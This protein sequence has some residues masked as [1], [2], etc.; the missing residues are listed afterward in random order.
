MCLISLTLVVQ[1]SWLID[2]FSNQLPGDK[3]PDKVSS[4]VT[5]TQWSLAQKASI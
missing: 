3:S 5:N 2:F 1:V 4:R